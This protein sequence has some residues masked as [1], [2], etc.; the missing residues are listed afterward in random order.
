[1]RTESRKASGLISKF[2]T[3]AILGKSMSYLTLCI[4]PNLDLLVSTMKRSEINTTIRQAEEFFDAH[5]FHLPP[6]AFFTPED[7]TSS[8][9]DLTMIRRSGLGWDVTDMGKGEFVRQGLVLFT[10]RNGNIN[11]ESDL[12]CY[13]E[14]IMVVREAQVTPWHFH[15]KK[16]EDIINRGGGILIVELAW[17][18]N[19][20]TA[21]TDQPVLVY[22]DGIPRK[23]GARS[24]LRLKPGE[25]ITLPPLLYH[26]FYGES[27][28]G[29]V[30]V[31]EVSRTNDDL[32]DNR[33]LAPLGRFPSII[34]DE[35]PYRL[36]CHEYP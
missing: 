30:L 8:T 5:Q 29:D 28:H 23:V 2:V 14:K 17:A 21:L 1:M 19:D 27:G 6:Y 31:G 13:A 32:T 24:P 7:W 33:F 34:E 22:C 25:S 20:E 10:L 11:D 36:L 16:T 18:S 3:Q 9:D 35:A 15:W 26:Q 4:K 12:K